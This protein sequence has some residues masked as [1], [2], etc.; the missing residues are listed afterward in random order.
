[1]ADT[2]LVEVKA[3]EARRQPVMDLGQDLAQSSL[4]HARP[5]PCDRLER[6]YHVDRV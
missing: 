6:L 2:L 4:W 3:D 5:G 1:V